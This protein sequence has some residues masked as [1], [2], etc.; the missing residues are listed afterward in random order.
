MQAA[1]IPFVRFILASGAD[2]HI[3]D[4]FLL[5]GPMVIVAIVL[6]GRSLATTL[7][8]VAYLVA[9]FGYT[10]LKGTTTSHSKI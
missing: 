8:A 6:L 3:F 2:D 7:L 1:D 9:F 10:L 5:A 4:A